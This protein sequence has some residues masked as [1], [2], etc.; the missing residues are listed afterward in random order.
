MLSVH[1]Q[2]QATMPVIFHCIFTVLAQQAI[3]IYVTGQ[4]Q[5]DQDMAL[6]QERW[7]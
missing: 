7:L 4:G 3:R 6:A 2:E 5:P 1:I